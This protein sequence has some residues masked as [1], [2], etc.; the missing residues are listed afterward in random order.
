MSKQ[1]IVLIGAGSLT[2]GL[3]TVGSIFE[4]Q[5]LNGATICLHDINEETL[6]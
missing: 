5:I 1:K 2:F 3:G 6:E 4:S